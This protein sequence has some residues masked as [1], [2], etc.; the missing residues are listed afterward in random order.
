VIELLQ[1]FD[2]HEP[3]ARGLGVAERKHSEF[4]QRL[5]IAK[6]GVADVRFPSSKAEEGSGT[7]AAT[8][9]PHGVVIIRV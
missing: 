6:S 2:M 4:R 3:G 8:R 7:G 5:A 1:S 9:S